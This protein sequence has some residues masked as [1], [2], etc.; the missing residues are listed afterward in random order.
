MGTQKWNDVIKW[1]EPIFSKFN[2]FD[3]TENDYLA[4]LVSIQNSSLE[5]TK[6]EFETNRDLIMNNYTVMDEPDQ[7]EDLITQISAIYNLELSNDEISDLV[8]DISDDIDSNQEELDLADSITL[9]L[10]TESNLL[11]EKKDNLKKLLKKKSSLIDDLK[12]VTFD[13]VMQKHNH[14]IRKLDDVNEFSFKMDDSNNFL[15]F[16]DNKAFVVNISAQS[17]KKAYKEYGQNC[18]PLYRSNLR[19]HVANK[20]IDKDI[21]DSIKEDYSDFWFKNNGIVIICNQLNF[22]DN[23]V[24]INNFSFING[25]QTSYMLGEVDF[26]ND[27]YILCKIILTKEMPEDER[28]KFIESVSIST[29]SQKPIKPS[30]LITNRTDIQKLSSSFSRLI[31]SM[32]LQ[33]KRGESIS[34]EYQKNNRWRNLKLEELG[35]LGLCFFFFLPGS[36]KNKKSSIW[37]KKNQD[38]LFNEEFKTTYFE[39]RKLWWIVD[40]KRKEKL[41]SWKKEK[42]NKNKTYFTTGQW[43][44]FIIIIIAQ[45]TRTDEVFE[46]YMRETNKFQDNKWHEKVTKYLRDKSKNIP[47]F[48]LQESQTIE[49]NM[50]DLLISINRVILIPSFDNSEAKKAGGQ[51]SNF[52]KSDNSLR[53]VLRT[54]SNHFDDYSG[55]GDEIEAQLDGVFIKK[56]NF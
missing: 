7:P 54:M 47:I 22:H 26:D 9:L 2:I 1:A 12:S 20:K 24:T 25:G 3:P 27:F 28:L 16:N 38:I 37:L 13:S 36:A 35:Q 34:N 41:F 18:G 4:L 45:L 49:I 31:P 42:N 11:K 39:L 30:D 52:V 17:V 33:L 15:K 44:L 6:D 10:F 40:K 32:N 50:V 8:D 46:Q 51:F 5:I 55:L 43:F 53:D 21:R 56:S 14:I 29:N 19:Y 48:R 23:Y